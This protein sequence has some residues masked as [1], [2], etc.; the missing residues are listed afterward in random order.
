VF[1]LH[2][3]V[4]GQHLA[5]APALLEYGA[6]VY[7]RQADTYTPLHTAAQNS[8]V[9]A[10]RL[11]HHGTRP[12]DMFRTR[13]HDW[14]TPALDGQYL[15]G[16][17]CSTVFGMGL[18]LGGVPALHLAAS[19]PVAGVVAMSTPT[20]SLLNRLPRRAFFAGLLGYALLYV[21]KGSPNPDTDP[22]HVDYPRYPV[23]AI[24]QLSAAIAALDEALLRVRVL[25]LFVHSRADSSV[26]LANLDTIATRLGSRDRS[27]LVLERGGHVVTE[28]PERAL[29]FD[30]GLASA[31]AYAPASPS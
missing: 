12:E 10:P 2:S 15:R 18:S 22:G 16:G 7:A 23:R 19:C 21:A 25:A 1:P 28:D 20:R 3:A 9:L 27:V 8:P 31:R 11:P 24:A 30:R 17:Q 5:M 6:D 14:L 13:W 4:V 29:R 26:A